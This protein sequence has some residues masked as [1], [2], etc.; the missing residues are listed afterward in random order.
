MVG[1][2]VLP[3]GNVLITLQAPLNKVVEYDA[4]GKAVW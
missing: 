3:N 4:D 1:N 2:D